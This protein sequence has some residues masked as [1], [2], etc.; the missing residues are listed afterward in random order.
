[1]VERFREKL[2]NE[3]LSDRIA[4]M[5][6]DLEGRAGG[7][8]GGHGAR[9]REATCSRAPRCRRRRS[10]AIALDRDGPEAARAAAHA[11]PHGARR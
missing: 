3:S 1:M 10:E 7:E 11:A 9:G 5:V 4:R 2:T 6:A 8:R